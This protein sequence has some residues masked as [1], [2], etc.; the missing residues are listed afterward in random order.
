[1][2]ILRFLRRPWSFALALALVVALPAP[3]AQQGPE[4]RYLLAQAF[5]IPSEYTNQESSYFSIVEG[6]NGNIYVGTAK[7]GVNAYLIEFNPVKMI[8]RMVVDVHRAIM[9]FLKGFGAQ[10]KIHTRNNVGK[11]GKIYIGSKQG[12]PEKNE[13]R[14]DYPGGYVL[15]YDPKTGK[16]EHFG[17]AKKHHGIISVMP[18]EDRGV[19]YISTCDD[20]R[21]IEH[22]HF[23]ILDLKKKTYRDLGDTEHSYAFIVLDNQGR[24]YHPVRGGL[25]ARYD[26]ARDKLEK[27]PVTVDGAA[28]PKDITKDGAILNWETSPD[29]KT[30]YAIEMSTNQLFS[31]DLTASG[32]SIPGKKLGALLS[33]GKSTDCRA[34][35]V[36]PKGIAW[37]TVTTPGKEGAD[38]HLVSYHPRDKG[39]RDLG[40]VG[41]ANADYTPFKDAKGKP[42]P[43]HHCVRKAKDGTLLPFVPLGICAAQDGSVYATTLAPLTILRFSPEVL[44]K[45]EAK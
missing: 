7:Y 37:A 25:I 35:A 6:H 30:L 15:T 14:T 16:T 41:I 33:G 42:L 36:S 31:F 29:K 39:P 10:A 4:S 28:P 23:M 2:F 11:S 45:A 9:K 44:K 43:W 24:A 26:P 20:G 32:N 38:F 3:T 1:M 17:I 21:P 18:D 27:L 12:Y 5:H 19:A 34:L 22:S 40:Q 8:A 13:K